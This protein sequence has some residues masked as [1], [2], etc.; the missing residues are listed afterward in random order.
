MLIPSTLLC[1]RIAS[2]QDVIVRLRNIDQ[3]LVR[4]WEKARRKRHNCRFMFISTRLA[5][6]GVNWP[7]CST[8]EWSHELELNA[9][10]SWWGICWLSSGILRKWRC[11]FQSIWVH[12]TNSRGTFVIASDCL[13]PRSIVHT[14][15]QQTVSSFPK[16][17]TKDKLIGKAKISWSSSSRLVFVCK[18]QPSHVETLEGMLN[19]T[20]SPHRSLHFRHEISINNHDMRSFLLASK[21]KQP[22][23]T[24]ESDPKGPRSLEQSHILT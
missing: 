20:S 3:I 17:Q 2:R 16:G 14:P 12:L 6:L 15:Q 8:Y 13:M 24:A 4:G 5:M 22:Q 23:N 21:N 1:P 11:V 7:C 10:Y 19:E 18:Q 9:I